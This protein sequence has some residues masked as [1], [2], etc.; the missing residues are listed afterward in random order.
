MQPSL[1]NA[2]KITFTQA[3]VSLVVGEEWECQNPHPDSSLYPPTLVSRSGSIRVVLLP[4]D[5]SDPALVADGLRTAFDRN[6]QAG[7]HTFRRQQFANDHG[8]RGVCV[9]YLQQSGKKGSISVVENS[10]YLV[11]NRT[12]RCVVVNYIASADTAD[13]SATHRMLLTGLSLQ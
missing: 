7:K 3:G 4:P 6:P 11:K 1:A 10:H 8:I 12:G 2:R 9:S 5:R 13:T